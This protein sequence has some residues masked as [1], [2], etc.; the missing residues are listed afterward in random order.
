[1]GVQ[2]LNERVGRRGARGFTLVELMVVIVII[3]LL[4]GIVG[5]NVM[6]R[7]SQAKITKA[8]AQ[9][10]VFNDAIIQFKL[11]TGLYPEYLEDLVV[12]PPDVENWA[13]GGYLQN[14]VQLPL[15]PWGYEYGYELA[16]GS[17]EYD[18][19]VYSLGADGQEGGEDEDGDLYNVDIFGAEEDGVM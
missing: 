17:E 1:M 6:S 15:D 2:R 18:Y 4:A 8:K 9:I 5:V 13:R 10:K 11:D 12:R 16:S 19:L 3:G 14:A 7:I